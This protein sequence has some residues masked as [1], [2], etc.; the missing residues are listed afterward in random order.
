MSLFVILAFLSGFRLFLSGRLRLGPRPL[1]LLIKFCLDSFRI[2]E[3]ISLA[4]SEVV[5]LFSAISDK[6]S[7]PVRKVSLRRALTPLQTM[8]RTQRKRLPKNLRFHVPVEHNIWDLY[9]FQ[10]P[11]RPV[12]GG[13]VPTDALVKMLDNSADAMFYNESP[14]VIFAEMKDVFCGYFAVF[15]GNSFAVCY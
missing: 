2:F 13:R 6:M 12:Y 7:P 4:S 9:Q 1:N 11:L 3:T 14:M 15:K 5:G 8:V 10:I